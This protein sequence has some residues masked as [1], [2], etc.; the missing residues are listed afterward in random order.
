M[1][2]LIVFFLLLL[3]FPAYAQESR[4]E[5]DIVQFTRGYCLEAATQ[6]IGA[7]VLAIRRGVPE[8]SPQQAAVFAPEG[9]RVF[10]FKEHAG[11][12]VLIVSKAG[13]CIIAA[14]EFDATKLWQEVDRWFGSDE[15]LRMTDE[16]KS[17]YAIE[18]KYIG[19][20]AE[21]VLVAMNIKNTFTE[22]QIQGML[23]VARVKD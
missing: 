1:K 5:T 2:K 15:K 22:G 9:G 4:L 19:D 20:F 13:P 17:S 7:D 16:V 3:S 14:R 21:Q 8:L 23:M 12:I 6:R 11:K 18:R 10:A